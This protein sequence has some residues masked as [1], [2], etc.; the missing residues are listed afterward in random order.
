MFRVFSSIRKSLLL[1]RQGSEGHVAENKTV[2]YLQ[3]AFGEFLLIVAGILV[4]LQIQNWNEG[5]KDRAEE[6]GLL[7]GLKVEFEEHLDDL[8]GSIPRMEKYKEDLELFLFYLAQED[9]QL[10]T[11]QLDRGLDASM[12]GDNWDP[13]GTV[14]DAMVS[15]GRLELIQDSELR[16]M[17]AT[18]ESVVDEVTSSENL[19]R[20]F[21]ANTLWPLLGEKGLPLARARRI[22]FTQ[23]P[24]LVPE[25]IADQQ[26][27]AIRGDQEMINM[28]HMRYHF[29][30]RNIAEH[31]DALRRVEEILSLIDKQI[32]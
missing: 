20:D 8:N 28:I 31:N 15:S 30:S 14:L 18:W 32:Q 26:Y 12:R 25:A 19:M 3:Y 16:S 24:D 7:R 11:A 27:R 17:L 5:R 2:R 29:R 4:A 10:S 13:V 1:R 6:Q 23:Y 22:S 9:I 21:L